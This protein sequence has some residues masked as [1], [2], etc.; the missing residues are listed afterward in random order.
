MFFSNLFRIALFCASAITN[1]TIVLLCNYK[2]SKKVFNLYYYLCCYLCLSNI[3][4]LFVSC[5]L[6]SHPNNNRNSANW[7]F[8]SN[9]QQ[10]TFEEHL[11]VIIIHFIIC[12]I[13]DWLIYLQITAANK[14]SAANNYSCKHFIEHAQFVKM[15][16]N[17]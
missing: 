15:Q 10:W 14:T 4:V 9:I 5:V 16:L 2:F 8:T 13:F 1:V 6:S 17:C 11:F 3:M 12:S 7:S